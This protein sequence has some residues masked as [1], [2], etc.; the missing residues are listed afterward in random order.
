M[1][2]AGPDPAIAPSPAVGIYRPRSDAR[3]GRRVR[4]G[5][6]LGSVDMLGILQEVI[7]PADGV[8]GASLAAAGD[9]VEYGQPLVRIEFA[10]TADPTAGEATPEPGPAG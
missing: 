6:V 7:A 2:S 8:V 5:D 3:T 1:R 9:A 4:A 10:P